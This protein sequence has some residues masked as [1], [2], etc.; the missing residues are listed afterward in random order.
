MALSSLPHSSDSLLKQALSNPVCVTISWRNQFPNCPII[1]LDL[2]IP[3]GPAPQWRHISTEI[4]LVDDTEVVRAYWAQLFLM[5]KLFPLDKRARSSPFSSVWL[6]ASSAMIQQHVPLTLIRAYFSKIQSD[7]KL[8]RHLGS[9]L[10]NNF[11]SMMSASIS[12][13]NGNEELFSGFSY[14]AVDGVETYDFISTLD[15]PTVQTRLKTLTADVMKELQSLSSDEP[16]EDSVS[17]LFSDAK[18]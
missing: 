4:L 6:V 18:S 5:D 12:A 3:R 10:A 7:R 17:F 11:V 9:P 13:G 1:K 2:D 15:E 16:V 8:L 14:A